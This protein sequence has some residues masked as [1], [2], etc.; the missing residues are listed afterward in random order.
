[1][2][3]HNMEKLIKESFEKHPIKTILRLHYFLL[4][5]E[6]EGKKTVPIR[7]VRIL[8]KSYLKKS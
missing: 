1:M 3:T 8:I 6:R 7:S 2:N 4:Q 5:L